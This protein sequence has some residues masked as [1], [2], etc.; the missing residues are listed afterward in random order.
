MATKNGKIPID[1]SIRI[2]RNWEDTYRWIPIIGSFIAFATAFSTGANSLP[3]PFS[4]SVGSGALTLFQASMAACVINVP[5]ATF[6]SNSTIDTMFADFLEENQPNEGFL[7]LSLLV[8]LITSVIWLTLATFLELPVSSQQ[9][10][11]SA[12]LGTMLVTKGVDFL[13]IKNKDK[14]QIFNGIGFVRIILEWIVA[15]PIAGLIA[16]CLFGFMKVFVLRQEN[17]EKRILIFL[18]ICFGISAGLLCFFLMFQVIPL[19]VDIGRWEA[20]LAVSLATLTAA[21]LSVI[22]VVPLARKRFD[23]AEKASI[24]KRNESCKHHSAKNLDLSP[25][26]RIDEEENF[27]DAL[28]EYME[29]RV[30]DTVY[31]EDERSCASPPIMLEPNQAPTMPSSFVAS[32]QSAPFKQL[33]EL[34]PNQLVQSRDFQRI[35]RTTPPPQR[36]N[37]SKFWRKMKVST[38]STCIEYGQR[39]LIRHSLAEKFDEK[40]ED[41]LGFPHLLAACIFALIQSAN[42]I[43][44][45]VGPYQAIIDIFSHRKNYSGNGEDLGPIQVVWWFRAIGGFSAS[46][47]FLLCG[48]RLIQCLGGKLTYVSNSRG[49][50]SLLCSVATTIIVARMKLPVS[51]THSFVGS[52]IGVGIAD[53]P[54]NVNWKLFL[55]FI[56]GWLGT[57]LFC[58][59]VASAI[60]SFTIYT[61]A[62]V[63]P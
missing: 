38:F 40:I 27:E 45:V 17:A 59:G 50:S 4:T 36:E 7:M 60:Y 56:C 21:L 34:T 20:I 8:V 26:K 54:R 2:V 28:K 23:S 3:N 19:V 37:F 53:D 43:A 1:L 52:L 44:A 61:P 32:S 9:S 33:L 10:M 30:L 15:P 46:M 49:F 62:Y 6:A 47:G 11:Q 55:K 25:N 31:E 57:I 48:R 29:M 12:L 63:V 58:C 13:S 18:P 39:T 16:F 14:N 51:S 24:N 22:V 41:M 5:G 42:E 35:D